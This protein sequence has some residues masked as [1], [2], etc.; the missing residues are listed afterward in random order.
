MIS[1][2]KNGCGGFLNK[3]CCLDT[4]KVGQFPQLFAQYK[5]MANTNKSTKSMD[6]FCKAAIG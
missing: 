4:K 6:L 3:Q 5:I 1:M 2:H